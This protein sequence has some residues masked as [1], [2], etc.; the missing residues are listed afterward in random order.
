MHTDGRGNP[1]QADVYVNEITRT[2]NQKNALT[3][4][5]NTLQWVP[6][7]PNVLPN[8]A[9]GYMEHGIGRINCMTFDP[10]NPSVYYV[11][12]AQGGL[13]KTGN[14][15][16][17]WTP[18]TDQ[19]P[20][21]RI[22]DVVVDPNNPSVLYISVCD[23]EYIGIGLRL[24]GRKRNTHY[25][26]G[27]YKSTNG[28][29]SWSPTGLSFQLTDGDAS[30]I[31]KILVH[32]N[33]SNQLVACGTSGMYVS[34]NAGASWT[35]TMDSLFW[36]LAEDPQQ[37]N[38][39]YAATGWVKNA[40]DGNAGIYKST[41]FGQS[42]TLLN[43]GI[44]PTGLVQRVK[45]AV[46]PSQP[47]RLYALT[48][49][50]LSG[51]YGIYTSANA[52]ASWQFHPPVSNLLEYDTGSGSGGQGN[53]DLALAVDPLNPGIVYTGGI[54]VWKSTDSAQTFQPVTHWTQ[55]YG[56]SIHC[57]IHFVCFQPQTGNF[58]VCSDGGLFRT[59]NPVSQSWTDANNGTPWPTVWTKLNDGIQVTS[60][61]RLS[62]SKTTSGRLLAGAQDNGSMVFDGTDWY[63]VFGGDGMDNYIFPDM[64]MTCIASSQYGN[65]GV[66]NDG[67][68]NYNSISPNLN[69]EVA[70]WTTPL[71]ASAS[72]PGL[73]YAGFSNVVMSNDYGNT[74]QSISS[75]PSNIPTQNEISALATAPSNPEVIY[76]GK[77]VRYEYNIPG[78]MY[79]TTNGGFSWT[80]VTAGLP[81]SLYYTSITINDVN[82]QQACVGMAGM[83]AG[84]KVYM[85][86]NNGSSWTNISYNLPN[87][88]V[89]ALAFLPGGNVLL[90]ATDIGIYS[91]AQGSTSWILSSAGLPN[92]IASDIE[93]NTALNKIYVSTFGRGIWEAD[94]SAIVSGVSN[95]TE[96]NARLLIAPSPSHGDLRIQIPEDANLEIIDI[97]GKCVS[98]SSLEKGSNTMHL[99]LPAG[100]YYFRATGKESGSVMISSCVIE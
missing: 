43:T 82:I 53:Y 4:S 34:N 39:L 18:L 77:R 14:A 6:K 22:S 75:F 93:V 51:L 12:V 71:A 21:T 37:P 45:I 3:K 83:V 61:Y 1:V 90:A 5:A 95:K 49:D 40:N 24:N 29:N 8:N 79:V 38:I 13:W 48:V 86:T 60:F 33:N 16:T 89:N 11:G 52:G 81:D 85:T 57:D 56:P 99:S 32:P 72:A 74:W 58:F 62:S 17:S 2:A 50:T 23:F 31:R 7:G 20:I 47:N 76:A 80:D 26:I 70:E 92:V 63:T 91:L 66:S 84:Q 42:W 97:M 67:G 19:L 44:P 88:P 25:G 69:S 41:D 87:L 59:L 9:T 28:G 54:N 55:F 64:D 15:G 30:L 94:L 100:V 73:L 36:D 27:V 68:I 96:K 35:K 65:F 98:H 46:S 78:S 10:T